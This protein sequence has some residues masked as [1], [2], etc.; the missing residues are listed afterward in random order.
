MLTI[1]KKKK[2][3]G[4]VTIDASSVAALAV[5]KRRPRARRTRS[6]SLAGLAPGSSGFASAYLNTLNDPFE[7]PAVKLGYDCFVPSSLH[8]A[9][10]RQK[11][12]T[13]ADGSFAVFSFPGSG[14]GFLN[15]NVS[16][17]AGVTWT[18]ASSANAA[19][20]L[21]NYT[22]ARFISGG[23]RAIALVADTNPSGVLFAGTQPIISMN[24]L[25]AT[26]PTTLSSYVSSNIGLGTHG[27]VALS[28]P[29][30]NDS[31]VF[32]SS[33]ITSWSASALSQ[34]SVPYIVGLG[35][36]ASTSVWV[37]VIQ[38]FEVLQNNGSAVIG[39]SND[40]PNSEPT[41]SDYFASPERLM[42]AIRPYLSNAGIMDAVG[43]VG[44]K[45]HP[46]LGLAV[47][48][49]R[50]AFGHGRNTPSYDAAI[51]SRSKMNTVVMEEMKEE[52]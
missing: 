46:A 5:S 2:K 42:S 22:A 45:I 7:Y 27:A 4:G 32:W 43:A 11:I 41:A 40:M 6:R 31:F 9:Y 48:A 8:T 12:T 23:I 3:G 24:T 34:A 51:H 16:G 14:T 26:S 1:F 19:A 28:R 33:H 25:Y 30:D 21:A 37:E 18:N 50:H 13:N 17:A 20:A 10:L 44:T 38:N 29:Q 36:P 49:A 39:L 52:L 47:S 35:F 15:T